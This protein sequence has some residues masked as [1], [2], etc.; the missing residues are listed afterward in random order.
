VIS[1]LDDYK[2]FEIGL[3][4]VSLERKS[5]NEF[6][7][8]KITKVLSSCF[9]LRHCNNG[10][11]LLSV[12]VLENVFFHCGEMSDAV[13]FNTSAVVY[14]TDGKNIKLMTKISAISFIFEG[15]LNVNLLVLIIS[16]GAYH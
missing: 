6:V 3:R 15:D 16:L 13:D 11:G 12:A 8:S 5:L 10:L 4:N 9:I 2:E 7:T 1:T 14:L